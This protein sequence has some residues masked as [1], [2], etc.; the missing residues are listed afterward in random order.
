MGA[1][2]YA[3]LHPHMLIPTWTHSVQY[4]SVVLGIHGGK[5]YGL[6]LSFS[7]C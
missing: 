5:S 3:S 6:L 2:S 4:S 1:V 7:L